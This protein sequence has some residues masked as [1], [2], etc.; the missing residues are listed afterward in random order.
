[1]GRGGP[2]PLSL[3]LQGHHVLSLQTQGEW[4]NTEQDTGGVCVCVGGY[5][6]LVIRDMQVR[7][8]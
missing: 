1:M 6:L 8:D 4:F 3:I 5:E 7:T 2:F